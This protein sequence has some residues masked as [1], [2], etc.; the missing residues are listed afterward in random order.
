MHH[1][2]WRGNLV[3]V[4]VTSAARCA[5]AWACVRVC[6]L[7]LTPSLSPTPTHPPTH[8]PTH[9]HFLTHTHPPTRA[10]GKD[11]EELQARVMAQVE[12][13]NARYRQ[14]GYEPVVWLERPVPL[15]ERIALYSIAGGWVGE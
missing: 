8:P 15:Y 4:Q 9:L 14:E 3:L 10:P 7:P 2:E 13:I 11:V 1:P 5:C 6:T 12:G